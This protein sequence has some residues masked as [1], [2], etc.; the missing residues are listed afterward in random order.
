MKRTV[1][2]F[3]KQRTVT[4]PT[5]VD[6][7][8]TVEKAC[9]ILAR[10]GDGA[11]LISKNGKVRGI[12]SERDLLK[13]Y[14]ELGE[15]SF[16]HLLVS[17]VMSLNLVGVSPVY[18]L[19]Q[20][21]LIMSKMKVRHLPVIEEGSVIHLLSLTQIAEVLVEDKDFIIHELVKYISGSQVPPD[22]V[23]TPEPQRMEN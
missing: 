17:E 20:C 21:L 18:T 19:E 16:G 10:A 11:I 9:Q 15:R 12:F 23:P 2:E 14:S 13:L 3:L 8:T 22:Q 1:N 4:R 5:V 6:A 7:E